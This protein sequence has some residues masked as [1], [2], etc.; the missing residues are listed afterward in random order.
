MTANNVTIDNMGRDS[1]V[2]TNSYL[3]AI[4]ADNKITIRDNAVS[5]RG[6]TGITH[7]LYGNLT[8]DGSGNAIEIASARLRRYNSSTLSAPNGRW[9]GWKST[10]DE[11]SPSSRK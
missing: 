7:R 10:S 1:S 2:S 8:A 6:G 3:P 5:G 11:K 4:N 9:L